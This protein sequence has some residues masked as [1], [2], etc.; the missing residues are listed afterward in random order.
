MD[1]IKWKKNYDFTVVNQKIIRICNYDDMNS[2]EED[3]LPISTQM[4]TLE[5][6]EA[7]RILK[8]SGLK[9]YLYL[10]SKENFTEFPLSAKDVVK[11]L[12][13]DIKTYHRAVNELINEEYLK[14]KDGYWYFLPRPGIENF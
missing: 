5:M 3:G 11:S 12:D 10:M 6:F 8:P 14:E 13:L 2:V 4:S 1:E 9:L 7:C